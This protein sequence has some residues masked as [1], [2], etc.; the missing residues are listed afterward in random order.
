ML[1]PLY[2]NKILNV[3]KKYSICRQKCTKCVDKYA[4]REY[5][6]PKVRKMHTKEVFYMYRNLEAEQRRLGKTNLEM[7]GILGISRSTYEKKKKTGL[8][9]RPQ[10]EILLNLFNCSFDYLFATDEKTVTY[11]EA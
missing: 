10:V 3:N 7:A 2:N 6:I 5:N 4:K 8:F 11:K 1:I 9:N